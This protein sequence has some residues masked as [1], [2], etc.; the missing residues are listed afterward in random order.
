MFVILRC[1]KPIIDYTVIEHYRKWYD[2]IIC[3][4]I[5]ILLHRNLL[6]IFFSLMC[7]KYENKM[8]V[9]VVYIDGFSN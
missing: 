5:V 4:S 1:N 9:I 2:I 7:C 6:R 8:I 3:N